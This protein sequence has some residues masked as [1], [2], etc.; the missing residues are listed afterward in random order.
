MQKGIVL[1]EL[2]E[3]TEAAEAYR[4]AEKLAETGDNLDLFIH[5]SNRLTNLMLRNGERQSA[6]FHQLNV[7]ALAERKL[8]SQSLALV[9]HLVAAGNYFAAR[10]WTEIHAWFELKG[11]TRGML[12]ARSFE[13]FNRAIGI[14][15]AHL[16]V[17]SLELIAPLRGLA[18]AKMRQ[19]MDTDDAEAALERI[20]DIRSSAEGD[21]ESLVLALIEL[22]DLYTVNNDKRAAQT[23]LKAWNH[24]QTENSPLMSQLFKAPVRLTPSISIR[25]INS[26]RFRERVKDQPYVRLEYTV[27][28]EGK[29][30]RIDALDWNIPVYEVRRMKDR[31]RVARYR[32]RIDN[33]VLVNTEGLILYQRYQW[34]QPP[35]A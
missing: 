9:P 19:N 26:P 25:T 5:A 27:T 28:A 14:T 12:F 34:R 10:G 31:L 20:V 4:Q 21:V 6:D 23:Y 30:R 16:G 13:L 2:G 35:E 15:E 1:D 29:V 24:L 3:F 11:P 8:G 17:D 33:G 18:S 22:G 7:V 32:P